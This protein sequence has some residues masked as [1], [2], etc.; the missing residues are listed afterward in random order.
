MEYATTAHNRIVYAA[1]A[2]APLASVRLGRLRLPRL[3]PAH[4]C[5]CWNALR[6]F[7]AT[8]KT[9]YTTGTLSDIGTTKIY[10]DIKEKLY[11]KINM[12]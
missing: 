9:S 6:S 10:I 1:G 5:G 3:T 7:I 12:E 4:F 11:Y 2:K 8:A